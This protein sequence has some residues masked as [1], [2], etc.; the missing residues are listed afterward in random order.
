MTLTGVSK[1]S[2]SKR[3][4]RFCDVPFREEIVWFDAG[5]RGTGLTVFGICGVSGGFLCTRGVTCVLPAAIVWPWA[6]GLP[7]LPPEPGLDSRSPTLG[8]RPFSCSPA[9]R[10]ELGEVVFAGEAARGAAASAAP[11]DIAWREAL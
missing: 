10:V 8:F 3:V 4:Y 11:M 9:G 7:L 2:F 5:T 6:F 1:E